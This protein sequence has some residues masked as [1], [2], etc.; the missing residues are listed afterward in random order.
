MTISEKVTATASRDHQAL[1]DQLLDELE[2]LPFP[3]GIRVGLG[4]RGV[5]TGPLSLPLAAV[6]KQQIAQF[7][8]WFD[9]CSARPCI[10]SSFA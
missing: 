4:V 5:P 10:A 2:R 8:G 1:L 6:R 3:W 9:T 7:R